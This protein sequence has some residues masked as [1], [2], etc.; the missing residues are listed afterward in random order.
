[1]TSLICNPDNV[2]RGKWRTEV[3]AQKRE[4]ILS[5]RII[6]EQQEKQEQHKEQENQED[7]ARCAGLGRT[8]DN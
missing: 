1:M 7:C 8:P 5:G 6:E 3:S 4:E 2:S